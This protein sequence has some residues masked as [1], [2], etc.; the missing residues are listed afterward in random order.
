MTGASSGIGVEIAREMARRGHGVTLVARREDRLRALADELE[1]DHRVRAEV[2]PT[3]LADSTQRQH[4]V[5]RLDQ[6][7]LTVDVLVNNAGVGTFGAVDDSDPE[8]ETTVVRTDVEAVVD[9]CSRFV[10]GMVDRG[11][12][13]VLNV[14][15]T[16]AYQPLPGQA[17]YGAAKAFVLSYSHA[18]RAELRGTGVTVTVLCPGPV[19]TEF[20][21]AGGADFATRDA[22]LP[23]FM[24]LPADRVAKAGVEGLAR[25]AA[26]VVPGMPNKITAAGGSILPHRLLAPLITRLHPALRRKRS[27]S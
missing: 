15:S 7:G 14:A 22:P 20:G 5:A 24:W 26:V 9:L 2:V 12:G 18:I 11:I 4:L 23:G 13:A 17:S 8:R 27:R 25:G 1:R 21:Q 19:H 6:Q 16:A 3:D 10:P